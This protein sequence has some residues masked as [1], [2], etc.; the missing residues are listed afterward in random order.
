[1]DCPVKFDSVLTSIKKKEEL[2]DKKER[3]EKNHFPQME[4][5]EI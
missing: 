4:T 2:I 3:N 5:K 1:M